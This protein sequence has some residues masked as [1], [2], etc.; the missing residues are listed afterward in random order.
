MFSN[1]YQLLPFLLSEKQMHVCYKYL[2]R[3]ITL[4]KLQ[5]H[6]GPFRN[7]ELP[8]LLFFNMNFQRKLDIGNDDVTT[9]PNFFAEGQTIT[10]P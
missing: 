10:T 3:I 4:P 1:T 2:A 5:I 8:A 7:Q 9:N 6:R